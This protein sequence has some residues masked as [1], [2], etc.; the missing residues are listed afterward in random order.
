MH[1]PIGAARRGW[2]VTLALAFLDAL[3]SPDRCRAGLHTYTR[4][5]EEL[6][7]KLAAGAKARRKKIRNIRKYIVRRAKTAFDE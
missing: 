4:Q 7:L 3:S 1:D 6:L 2:L 5:L